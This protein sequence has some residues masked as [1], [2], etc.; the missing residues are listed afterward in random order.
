MAVK[1]INMLIYTL[2][3]PNICSNKRRL[4]GNG[5]GLRG[6]KRKE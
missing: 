1:S 2:I 6:S 4:E 3:L 5:V